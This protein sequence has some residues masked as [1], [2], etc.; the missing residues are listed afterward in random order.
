MTFGTCSR[1]LC[2]LARTSSGHLVWMSTYEFHVNAGSHTYQSDASELTLQ[3]PTQALTPGPTN[4]PQPIIIQ[5]DGSN[6][7]H[8]Y[9]SGDQVEDGFNLQFP[10]LDDFMDWKHQEEENK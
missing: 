10:T 1:R 9:G 8:L 3:G 7:K 5:Y 6:Q 4:T 2:S